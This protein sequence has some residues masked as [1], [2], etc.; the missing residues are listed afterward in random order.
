MQ[1]SHFMYGFRKSHEPKTRKF[2]TNDELMNAFFTQSKAQFG[3]AVKT[4]WFYSGDLCS[5]CSRPTDG[6]MKFKGKEALSLN[7]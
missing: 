7:A 2:S 6:V 5:G 3:S 1:I 4:Y